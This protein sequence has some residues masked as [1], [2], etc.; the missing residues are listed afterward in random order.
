MGLHGGQQAGWWRVWVLA[1]PGSTPPEAAVEGA[2]QAMHMEICPKV[3]EKS[4][5]PASPDQE[6]RPGHLLLRG[7]QLV[8]KVPNK[9]HRLG[10]KGRPFPNSAAE[11]AARGKVSA[12]QALRQQP[13]MAG[14]GSGAWPRPARSG[15]NVLTAA[16]ERVQ[17][18][19]EAMDGTGRASGGPQ[20]RGA[21]R[22]REDVPAGV[23]ARGRQESP[24]RM[25]RAA[26]AWCSAPGAVPSRRPAGIYHLRC[27]EREAGRVSAEFPVADGR[28]VSVATPAHGQRVLRLHGHPEA[29]GRR[30][31]RLT[32][33]RGCLRRLTAKSRGK[34]SQP[35]ATSWTDRPGRVGH[36]N[37]CARP[38]PTTAMSLAG[39]SRLLDLL[40]S[41]ET[42]DAQRCPTHP[43]GVRRPPRAT[44]QEHMMPFLSICLVRSQ[45]QQKCPRSKHVLGRWGWGWERGWDSQHFFPHL[46]RNSNVQKNIFK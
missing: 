19:R 43:A 39:A 7:C 16:A 20:R 22:G 24:P 35:Q 32:A 38:P 28:P 36:R 11:D 1:T 14:S 13:A 25:L 29:P 4:H 5:T 21:V 2:G 8:P 33:R 15:V 44:Q 41:R 6:I 34:A 42:V 17:Y 40:T 23:A 18:L 27:P 26:G 37:A 46:F 45:R 10:T 3:L 30:Q 9:H 12:P 31:A